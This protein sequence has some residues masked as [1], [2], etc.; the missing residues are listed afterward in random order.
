MDAQREKL[1]FQ[2]V[3]HQAAQRHF[4]ATH[5]A[6]APCLAT[7]QCCHSCIVHCSSDLL[8]WGQHG[9]AARW[10]SHSQYCPGGH[11]SARGQG[12]DTDAPPHRRQRSLGIHERC[13]LGK[14]RTGSG[15][16][17]RCWRRK[18]PRCGGS[19]SYGDCRRHQGWNDDSRPFRWYGRTVRNH[20]YCPR[21]PVPSRRA[22]RRIWQEHRH[23]R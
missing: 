16:G 12:P 2:V 3:R 10:R 1:H 18:R 20:H 4:P 6:T 21:V 19:G 11:H 22:P 14:F 13:H 17:E 9:A 7:A 5:D 23:S 15:D 8:R